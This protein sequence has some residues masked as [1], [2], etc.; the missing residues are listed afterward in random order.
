MIEIVLSVCLVANPGS[1]KDVNLTYMAESVTPYQCMVYGQSEIAKW[2]NV[3]PKW[4][5][6]RW[7]CGVAREYAKA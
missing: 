1:C 6:Q 2:V 7:K 3:H 5:V 4:K